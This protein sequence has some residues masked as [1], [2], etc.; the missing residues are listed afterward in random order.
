[1]D[2]TLELTP[3]LWQALWRGVLL[4]IGPCIAT[5][6]FAGICT[7]KDKASD[8]NILEAVVLLSEMSTPLV[9]T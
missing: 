7:G 2:A 3:L 6:I 1:M 8:T 4:G 5:K 9:S